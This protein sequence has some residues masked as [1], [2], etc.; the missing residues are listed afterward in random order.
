MH[1][2]LSNNTTYGKDK[3]MTRM[4][5]HVIAC[6]LAVAFC[7]IL[8]LTGSS[9]R[10]APPAGYSL[11]WS[12]EFSGTA[13]NWDNWQYK[14][15]GTYRDG[16]NSASA[17][18]VA[19]GNMT[20]TT[21]TDN[22]VHYTAWIATENKFQQCFGYYEARI[23]FNDSPGMWSAFWLLANT[24]G[25]EPF[26]DPATNGAEIDVVEHR[27][28]DNDYNDIDDDILVGCHWNGYGEEHEHNSQSLYNLGIDD[29]EFHLFGVEWDDEEYR[30]YVDGVYKWSS[31]VGISERTEYIILS[32]EVKDMMW[33][34]AIP[35]GGYGSLET[36]TTK[37]VV[38]YVRVYQTPEPA[39]CLTVCTGLI[40]LLG[41]SR[42]RKVKNA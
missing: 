27:L 7:C 18:S 20:I 36:S 12:D 13:L 10:A 24:V 16:Y 39:T 15:Q 23:K 31:Y 37:M 14:F 35:T 2:A 22:D 5:R 6:G 19:D 11:T 4:T 21:Y 3:K 34:G 9:A 28:V 17:V 1:W 33:S 25:D 29:G 38:D 8:E 42:K 40:Y 30:Y 41:K 26:D 32:S